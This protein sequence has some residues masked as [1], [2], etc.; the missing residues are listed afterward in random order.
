MSDEIIVNEENRDVTASVTNAT[1]QVDPESNIVYSIP[2]GDWYEVSGIPISSVPAPY[3]RISKAYWELLMQ[4]RQEPDVVIYYDEQ[5]GYPVCK[6]IYLVYTLVRYKEYK[7][8]QIAAQYL[9]A[10]QYPFQY[11]NTS[12]VLTAKDVNDLNNGVMVMAMMAK[13]SGSPFSYV[14]NDK[15]NTSYTLD[16]DGTLGLYQAY[17][18]FTNALKN[19]RLA[20][21]AFIDKAEKNTDINELTWDNFESFK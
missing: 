6:P 18:N 11:D 14:L 4:Q 5:L 16:A 21:L 2:K 13:M 9:D 20:I 17:I 1:N 10:Q 3:I 19:K 12:W 8:S 7:K 15:F